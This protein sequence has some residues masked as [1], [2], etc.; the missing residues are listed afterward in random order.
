MSCAELGYTIFSKQYRIPEQVHHSANFVIEA[1]EAKR[2]AALK[3][4]LGF[5]N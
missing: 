1:L 4:S 3:R 2:G 5:F